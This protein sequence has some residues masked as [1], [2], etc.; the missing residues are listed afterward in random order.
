MSAQDALTRNGTPD[1]AR[2]RSTIHALPEMHIYLVDAR[3]RELFDVRFRATVC[4]ACP[5]E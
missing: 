2:G 4:A 3:G 5:T 1:C